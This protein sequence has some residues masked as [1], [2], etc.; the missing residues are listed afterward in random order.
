MGDSLLSEVDIVF[1]TSNVYLKGNT[2]LYLIDDK[3]VD[4]FYLEYLKIVVNQLNCID[5]VKRL[6]SITGCDQIAKSYYDDY[7]NK[8]YNEFYNVAEERILQ[9][10]NQE[11]KSL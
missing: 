5:L 2:Y 1:R 7:I 11:E 9:L 6:I 4:T 8:K 10:K 3:D